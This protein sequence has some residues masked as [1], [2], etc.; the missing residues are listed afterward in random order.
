MLLVKD[1]SLDELMASGR[2]LRGALL[3]SLYG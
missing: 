2:D 3:K 1:V